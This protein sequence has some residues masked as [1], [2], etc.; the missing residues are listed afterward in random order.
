M[1]YLAYMLIVSLFLLTVG[2]DNKDSSSKSSEVNTTKTVKPKIYRFE[3]SDIDKRR[4]TI[5][6][7]DGELNIT[8]VKQSIVILNIFASWSPACRGLLAYLGDL[9]QSYSKDMFVVGV[10]VNSSM[11]DESL[12]AFMNRYKIKYFISNSSDNDKLASTLVKLLN[13]DSNYPIPLTVVFEDGL[14]V[15]HYIGATPIEMIRS[16]IEQLRRR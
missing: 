2:C 13:I 10:M 9:Q 14:Y 11:T 4:A 7:E 5:S 6:I 15:T 3:I 16:D 12:R 8:K 1:K